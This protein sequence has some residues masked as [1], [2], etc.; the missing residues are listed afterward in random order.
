MVRKEPETKEDLLRQVDELERI[1]KKM[2]KSG[3]I[4]FAR[5]PPINQAPG[6]ADYAEIKIWRSDG[7]V[8]TLRCEITGLDIRDPRSG[9]DK[10]I[11]SGIR[12]RYLEGDLVSFSGKMR[13]WKRGPDGRPVK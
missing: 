9:M 3:I 1:A 5:T 10:S 13:P 2:A 7:R 12:P 8:E 6:N 4:P 11:P